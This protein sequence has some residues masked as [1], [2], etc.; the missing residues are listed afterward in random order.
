MHPFGSVA[1]ETQEKLRS[2]GASFVD[3]RAEVLMPYL[4]S[5]IFVVVIVFALL[6][7]LT[8]YFLLARALLPGF[9]ARAESAWTERPIS[10]VALGIPVALLLGLVSV[11]LIN[12]PNGALRIV[13]FVASSVT[14]GFIFAGTAGL[15][16]RI[17][18][19]L[20]SPRDEGR[21]WSRLLR[22]GI[23][24]EL[25]MLFPILGWFL[26]VPIAIVGGAGAA[27]L[28]LFRRRAPAQIAESRPQAPWVHDANAPAAPHLGPAQG[29]RGPVAP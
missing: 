4:S 28:A 14:L 10:V 21:E 12:A 18:Q 6:L 25:S 20:R 13:G 22:A 15:A 2:L 23:V 24:L 1:V 29:P 3:A 16:A 26:I 8:G 19:G 27:T 7:S 17:G 9:V 5:T 11:G